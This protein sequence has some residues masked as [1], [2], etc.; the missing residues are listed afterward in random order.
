[1]RL[2]RALGTA[3]LACALLTGC[4]G[5]TEAGDP[6][7]SET[8]STTPAASGQTAAPALD[9][10]HAVDPPGRR[11]GLIAPADIVANGSK[12]IPQDKV[13]AI[14]RLDGVLDVEQISLASVPVENRT[15]S[16]AAVDPATYRNWVT[17][18]ASAQANQVWN[19]V[20]GGELAIRPALEKRAPIDKEGFLALGS[21]ADAAKV[22]VGAYA[23]QSWLVDAVVNETWIKDL[24]MTEGNALLIRTGGTA[25]EPLRKPIERI[26]RGTDAAV[27]MTDVVAREGL[28]PGVVQTAV[29]VGTI[30]D[31]V[32]TFRY[33]VL[34]GGHIA[35]DPAWVRSHIA[36]EP[37]PILGNVTC[38]KL[39]FPQLRAALEDVITQGLADTI[40]PTQYAG[41]FY[42]RFIAGTTTLSNHAFGLALDI[43]AVENQRG[44]AGRIDR[45]VVAIFKHW[46]F[47][48]GGDWHYTDPMHFEMN[49]LVQPR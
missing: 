28:D 1:M 12:T 44:T 47:T 42:P 16:V 17:K 32:G 33:T 37:V 30:A 36:T 49:Q 23:Q 25:P 11:T 38:N 19:R 20:A 29:V 40:H 26:L 43:N 6:A 15:L 3:A 46:G 31:A 34:S 10:K 35:P 5:S 4:N 39:I 24:D 27:S 13:D 9:P 7:P 8:T 22:H 45:G 21:T 18:S 41:C 48:W 2:G 14:R